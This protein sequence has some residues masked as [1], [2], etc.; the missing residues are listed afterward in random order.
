M[1]DESRRISKQGLLVSL[2]LKDTEWAMAMSR[3]LNTSITSA[4]IGTAGFTSL[5]M[6]KNSLKQCALNS[7]GQ[8]MTMNFTFLSE[9][10]YD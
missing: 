6:L 10:L 7:K 2:P 4:S 3:Y 5:K 1:L 8:G 9:F